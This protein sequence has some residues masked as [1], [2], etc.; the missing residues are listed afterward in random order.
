[1][2]A[3][4]LRLLCLLLVLLPLGSQA[5][6]PTEQL[7]TTIDSVLALLKQNSNAPP[8]DAIKKLVSDRFDYAEMSRIALGTHWAAL[9]TAQQQEFSA[10]FQQL[11]E[12]SYLQQMQTYTN[13]TVVYQ[14]EVLSTKGDKAK[15]ATAIARSNGKI[16]VVYSLMAKST[17]TGVQW[18]VYDVQI[19]GIRLVQNYRNNF[20]EV[21]TK[22]GYAALVK[23]LQ[24][25]IATF[26]NPV[27]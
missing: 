7:Q 15:V 25:K 9:S 11:L 1:M 22:Q 3:H 10:L 5:G 26:N 2:I 6:A 18:L 23:Q 21:L 8:T 19:E 12:R 16:P 4:T 24:D 14:Q 17:A 13:E 20:N 27:S